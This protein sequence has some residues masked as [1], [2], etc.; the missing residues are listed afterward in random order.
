M[1][2]PEVTVQDYKEWCARRL[3]RPIIISDSELE[4]VLRRGNRIA[5]EHEDRR[6]A[7]RAIADK[8]FEII[9]N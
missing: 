6:E 9:S 8:K 7:A 5:Q 2:L 3:E 1:K 4:E